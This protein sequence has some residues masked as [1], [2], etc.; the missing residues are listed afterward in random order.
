MIADRAAQPIL[1]VSIVI[2]FLASLS[3]VCGV[4]DLDLRRIQAR[5]YF[6]REFIYIVIS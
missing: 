2:L 6:R 3:K 4:P 5:K 1:H